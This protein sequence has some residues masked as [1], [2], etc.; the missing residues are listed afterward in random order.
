MLLFLWT[1]FCRPRRRAYFLS[2]RLHTSPQPAKRNSWGLA[3]LCRFEN[4]QKEGGAATASIH[5]LGTHPNNDTVKSRVAKPALYANLLWCCNDIYFS[6]LSAL[7]EISRTKPC[8]DY[9][10]GH[11]QIKQQ[12]VVFGICFDRMSWIGRVNFPR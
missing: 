9:T 10:N 4:L 6:V 5:P 7:Q 12:M 2:R 11:Y 8:P 1:T 3:Q